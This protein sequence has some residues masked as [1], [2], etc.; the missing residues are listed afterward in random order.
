MCLMCT[1]WLWIGRRNRDVFDVYVLAMDDGHLRLLNGNCCNSG[2]VVVSGCVVAG[3]G[4][5]LAWISVDKC[6]KVDLM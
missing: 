3:C 2:C 1:Y 6:S 4:V 5:I